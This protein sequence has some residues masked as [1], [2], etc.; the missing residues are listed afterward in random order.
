MICCAKRVSARP[1]PRPR[2]SPAGRRIDRAAVKR[3]AWRTPARVPHQANRYEARSRRGCA[4]VMIQLRTYV[5]VDSLQPQLAE[6]LG[7][8]SQ[9]FLPVPGAAC[10]WLVGPPGMAGHRLSVVAPNAARVHPGHHVGVRAF[11]A[12]LI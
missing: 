4:A 3:R 10:L 11:G 2:K 6:Y 12:M 7:T 5:Y 1:R 9:G 8:V